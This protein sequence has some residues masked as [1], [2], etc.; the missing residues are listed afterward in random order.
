MDCID[1]FDLVLASQSG[2]KMYFKLTQTLHLLRRESA[3]NTL[4]IEG[5]ME[6]SFKLRQDIF[7]AFIAGSRETLVTALDVFFSQSNR[8][9]QENN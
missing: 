8:Y 1:N 5:G 2:N 4:R 9:Y 7:D 6:F 3:L